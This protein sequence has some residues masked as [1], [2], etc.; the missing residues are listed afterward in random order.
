MDPASLHEICQSL[1]AF[2]PDPEVR[3]KA[4]YAFA[5]RFLPE[6]FFCNP[7]GVV[8]SVY[9]EQHI[10]CTKFIQARWQMM[11]ERAGLVEQQPRHARPLRFRRVTDL[12]AWKQEICRHPALWVKMP[13]PEHSPQAYFV[14][15]VLL[16]SASRPFDEWPGDAVGRLF[17][18]ERTVDNHGSNGVLCE[19][20]RSGDHHNF[21]ALAAVTPVGFVGAVAEVLG[22]EMGH[23]ST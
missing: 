23:Q 2:Y 12:S 11:E 17:T 22:G 5:H 18:L 15:A 8:G 13:E 9:I 10:D 19:W 21:G 16:V 1:N 7:R 6:Y 14:S 4:H 20:D 3:R